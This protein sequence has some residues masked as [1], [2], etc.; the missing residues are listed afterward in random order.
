M[1]QKIP[2]AIEAALQPDGEGILVDY[3]PNIIYRDGKRT[4]EVAGLKFEVCC[5]PTFDVITVKAPTVKNFEISREELNQKNLARD[6]V[7]ITFEGWNGQIYSDF[8]TGKIR[9]SATAENVVIKN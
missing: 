3:S 9:I 6:F 2:C 4:D 7:W 1:K 5:L 8:R